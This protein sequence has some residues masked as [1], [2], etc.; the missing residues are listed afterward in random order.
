MS[1]DRQSFR[2]ARA[3]QKSQLQPRKRKLCRIWIHEMET[4][5]LR[6]GSQRGGRATA[7]RNHHHSELFA[8][9]LDYPSVEQRVF[10]NLREGQWQFSR[11]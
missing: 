7:G 6:C 9:A 5:H 4:R 10:A 11:R 3:L 2:A 8:Q 1:E